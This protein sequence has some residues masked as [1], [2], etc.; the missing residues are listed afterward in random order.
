MSLATDDTKPRC[1]SV[2]GMT[3]I[4]AAIVAENLNEVSTKANFCAMSAMDMKALFGTTEPNKEYV[5]LCNK[6]LYPIYLSGLQ[7][8]IIGLEGYI[9]SEIRSESSSPKNLTL[10]KISHERLH[11]EKVV[12]SI[13]SGPEKLLFIPNKALFKDKIRKQFGNTPIARNSE[14]FIVCENESVK[15]SFSPKKD[16]PNFTLDSRTS[17]VL[18][19]GHHNSSRVI[20]SD[21][22][23]NLSKEIEFKFNLNSERPTRITRAQLEA[24]PCNIFSNG[25]VINFDQDYKI[26]IT[27][28]DNKE[29][30]FRLSLRSVRI[31]K[32]WRSK[33]KIIGYRIPIEFIRETIISSDIKIQ[34]EQ[35]IPLEPIKKVEPE[36][37]KPRY[38]LKQQTLSFGEFLKQEGLLGLSAEVEEQIERVMDWYNP[39]MR[40]ELIFRNVQPQKGMLFYGPPGCGKTS[41]VETIAKY[42]GIDPKSDRLVKTGASSLLDQYT[43]NTEKFIGDLFGKAKDEYARNGADSQLYIIFIDELEAIARKRSNAKFNWEISRVTKLLD[44]LDGV[45]KFN[46]VL[47]IGATNHFEELDEALLRYGRF[48][49]KI[50]FDL[51]SE[52]V[53]TEIFMHYFTKANNLIE[54]NVKVAELAKISIG[55][56]GADIRGVV[57]SSI[58]EGFKRVKA[59]M[60]QGKI[61]R[62]ELRTHPEGFAKMEELVQRIKAERDVKGLAAQDQLKQQIDAK[63]Q[64]EERQKAKD[65]EKHASIYT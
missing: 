28:L 46:N 33:D 24:F 11:V 9:A 15:L 17:L 61:T 41:V 49:A 23:L 55:L 47:V 21:S 43:G 35:K 59:L 53:R 56:S 16:V 54:P 40:E 13:H 18:R 25:D 48:G 36:P 38:L 7:E 57:E 37:V 39:E 63:K 32:V 60:R 52:E 42:C 29:V 34:E 14:Y 62:A 20:I 44:L 8:G 1:L 12:V 58:A 45:D 3:D 4:L 2:T 65:E 19:R 27:D 26:S 30:Q 51:P 10:C 22:C 5:S 31:N 6:I 50:K 64:E